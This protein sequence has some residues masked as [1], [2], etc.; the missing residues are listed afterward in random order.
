S[1]DKD[2]FNTVN[3]LIISLSKESYEE[4]DAGEQI[5]LNKFNKGKQ[6]DYESKARMQV[7]EGRLHSRSAKK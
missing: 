1:L 4:I 2:E 3:A 6:L 5:E 7:T